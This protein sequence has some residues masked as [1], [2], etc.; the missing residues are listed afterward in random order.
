MPGHTLIEILFS[1]FL[2]AIAWLGY[3]KIHFA[4]LRAVNSH[5][6]LNISIQQL[7]SLHDAL[8]LQPSALNA[9]IATWNKQ[10]QMMLP[11]GSGVIHAAYPNLQA[12]LYWGKDQSKDC[13]LARLGLSGCLS[14]PQ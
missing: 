14:L 3:E 1:C 2:L 9:F 6:N 5:A 8:S 4:T 10:N 11:R 12:T 13:A 7:T